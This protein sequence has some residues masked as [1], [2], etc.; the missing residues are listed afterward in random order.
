MQL[1]P[2][3]NLVI[4]LIER[5]LESFEMT[6]FLFSYR[7]Y[8]LS[9]SPIGL[10][11]LALPPLLVSHTGAIESLPCAVAPPVASALTMLPLFPH[12]A[13][14]TP[15]VSAI[16]SALHSADAFDVADPLLSEVAVAFDLP[17]LLAKAVDD[18]PCFADAYP[19]QSGELS[20]CASPPEDET[21]VA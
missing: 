20:A 7:A 16:A 21:A 19:T 3:R 13:L 12:D 11:T 5:M 10:L 8:W 9:Q 17:V 14:A 15:F 2:R 6:G 4:R 18:P 1:P